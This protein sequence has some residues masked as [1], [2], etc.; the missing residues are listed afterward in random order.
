ML[1]AHM[2]KMGTYPFVDYITQ[3]YYSGKGSEA[4]VRT[5]R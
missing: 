5:E 3:K 4:A 1:F 2:L